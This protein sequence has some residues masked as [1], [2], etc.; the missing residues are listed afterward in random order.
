MSALTW[1]V[2]IVCLVG[3]VGAAAC[4]VWLDNLNGS[5]MALSAVGVLLTVLF[6]VLAAPDVAH[7]EA[8]VGA[9]VLPL[10]YLVAIGKVRV[11]VGAT[12][13]L[14]EEGEEE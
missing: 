7:S 14:S 11:W 4:V 5:I 2:D 8:V 3:I 10:L 6:V 1:V 13:E 12:R 9:I